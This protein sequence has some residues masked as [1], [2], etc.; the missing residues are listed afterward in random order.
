MIGIGAVHSSKTTGMVILKIR[1]HCCKTPELPVHA[2]ILPKLT[3]TISSQQLDTTKWVQFSSLQLADPKYEQP[4]KIDI[5]LGSDIY[6]Q[7]IEGEIIR[8]TNTNPNAQSTTFGWVVSGCTG[9]Q[10]N[11]S[12]NQGYQCSLD[13]DLY[14]LVEMF[15][16]QDDFPKHPK[17]QFTSSEQECEDHCVKTHSRDSSGRY[18]V[19]IPFKDYPHKL[20]NSKEHAY[21]VLKNIQRKF[22]I[23]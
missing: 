15:W 6:A 17:N 19:R 22:S 21:C 16:K 14:K 23:N 5:L 12:I 7:I 4:E 3:S 8:S 1:P 9:K 18:I 11:R 2:Y 13:Q 10:F 20:G